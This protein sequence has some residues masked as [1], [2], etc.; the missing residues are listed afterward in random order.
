MQKEKYTEAQQNTAHFDCLPYL[1]HPSQVLES[2]LMSWCFIRD[3][4]KCAELWRL[5]GTGLRITALS[6]C[7]SLRGQLKVSV[8]CFH[9]DHFLSKKTICH[10]SCRY[11]NGADLLTYPSWL[12]ADML[13][14][15]LNKQKKHIKITFAVAHNWFV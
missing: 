14:V 8:C 10:T 4:T 2:L 1:S 15:H 9:T 13:T 6:V 12:E 5:P 11:T 3:H 7:W